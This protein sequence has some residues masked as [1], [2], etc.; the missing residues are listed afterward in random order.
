MQIRTIGKWQMAIGVILAILGVVGIISNWGT[1]MEGVAE[2]F[3]FLT[4]GDFIYFLTGIG[5]IL[6]SLVN[7]KKK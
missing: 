6:T 2:S 4:A 3:T 5:F 7:L 1:P